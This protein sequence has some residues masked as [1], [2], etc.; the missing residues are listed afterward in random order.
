V[1]CFRKS[2]FSL[3]KKVTTATERVGCSYEFWFLMMN[4]S[5]DRRLNRSIAARFPI[6]HRPVAIEA[7]DQM[8]DALQLR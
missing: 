3:G 2:P 1:G 5:R 6:G 7:I 4:H 8:N